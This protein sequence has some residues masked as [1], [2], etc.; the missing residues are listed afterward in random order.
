MDALPFLAAVGKAKRQPVYV[1]LGDEDFLKRR[2]RDAIVKHAL[3]DADPA[4]AVS[5]YA[6]DKL[7]FSTVRND[8]DTLPFLS[9]CRVV[10]VDPADAF[11]TAH[12]PAL[13][14]Y[15]TAPAAAGVLVLDVKAFPETTKLAKALPDAAKVSCKA[16]PPYKLGNWVQEWA[17]AGHG[18][19]LAPDAAEL[20][21]DLVGPNM[22][23][24]D[25][26]LEKLAVAVGGKAA[27]EAADVDRL[28]GRS[29]G[30]DVFRILDAVGDGK[31]AAALGIL[32]RLFAEGE[33][34]MAVLGPL[35]AQL[36]K[37]A[38]V[39]R[40]LAEG[41]PLGPAMDAA[42]VPSWPQARQSFER[43]VRWLGR[44][45]LDQLTDWLVEINHGLKGGNP[46]PERL[47][48]ERL[49]VKLARPRGA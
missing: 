10:V 19:K 25:Q 47:Q 12:R 34:P 7:D 22:G 15:V 43:Q 1:L 2:C 4:F 18:K 16:P 26:E 41:L 3:G 11:V 38:A 29:Q 46:L 24:L 30:A 37:L 44:R 36:R 13:E 20:L 49:V 45:R 28:V 14:K 40:S 21:V 31:P 42:K 8:L 17:K 5:A 33:D 48:V 23:Q 27:V 32:E 9:P 6:G 35:T 39:G